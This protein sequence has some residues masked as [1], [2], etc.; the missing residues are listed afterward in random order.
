MHSRLLISLLAVG[1]LCSGCDGVKEQ[2]GLTRHTPD[3]FSVMQRAPLEI[4][5]NLND[6][7]P[8]VL[9]APRPQEVPAV[10]QAQEAVLG[11]TKPVVAAAASKSETMLINKVASTKA[12]PNIR[13]QLAKDAAEDN[14]DS[15]PVVKRLLNIG[16]DKPSSTIVDSAAEAQRIMDAKKAGKPVTDGETPTIEE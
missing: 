16:S 12:D 14:E 2:L 4:P 6:L 10:K 3:E 1:F 8:P 13:Q 9:G 15:R 11:T 7:P 5:E